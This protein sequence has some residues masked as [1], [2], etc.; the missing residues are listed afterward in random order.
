MSWE[1]EYSIEVVCP[2][3]GVIAKY[4]VYSDDWMRTEE[5]WQNKENV[6]IIVLKNKPYD[7]RVVYKCKKCGAYCI[8]RKV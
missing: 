5:R 7:E 3:C 1:K 4:D 6:E 8:E 2:N